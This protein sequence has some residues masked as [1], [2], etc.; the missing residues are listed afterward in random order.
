MYHILFM[1]RRDVGD[2]V[3]PRDHFGISG[4]AEDRVEPVDELFGVVFG[5]L[6]RGLRHEWRE[7]Q[8]G[9]DADRLHFWR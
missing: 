1:V 4:V 6:W 8:N 3:P 2:V 5:E 7:K 9:G